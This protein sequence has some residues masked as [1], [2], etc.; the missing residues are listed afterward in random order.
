MKKKLKVILDTNIFVASIWRGGKSGKII[1]AWRA[2]RIKLV[3][4]PA[5]LR[6]YRFILAK[7]KARRKQADK[8]LKDL[9]DSVFGHIRQAVLRWIKIALECPYLSGLLQIAYIRLGYFAP[10]I[11]LL[12]IFFLALKC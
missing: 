1:E 3:V 8:L 5:I 6:E 12:H 9:E 10:G 2:G 11:N 7:M 4:S